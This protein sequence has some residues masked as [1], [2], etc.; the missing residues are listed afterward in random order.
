MVEL[1]I[2]VCAKHDILEISEIFNVVAEN[3]PD[4]KGFYFSGE[5]PRDP[6]IDKNV[7]P[8]PL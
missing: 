8:E 2:L 5:N 6:K 3:M 1:Q 4:L 7:N